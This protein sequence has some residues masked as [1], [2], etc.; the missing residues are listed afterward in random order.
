MEKDRAK[1]RL[2]FRVQCSGFRGLVG[3]TWGFRA[4]GSMELLLNDPFLSQSR[5]NLQLVTRW[6][7][8]K[9]LSRARDS[10]L[11]FVSGPGDLCPQPV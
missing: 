10:Y 9:A 5:E 11:L 6:V 2:G 7:S 3:F 1:G 8:R 4:K